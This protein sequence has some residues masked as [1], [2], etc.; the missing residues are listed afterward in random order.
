MVVVG[1]AAAQA[2]MGASQAASVVG[3][4]AGGLEAVA[5]AVDEAE[6]VLPSDDPRSGGAALLTLFASSR[7][8]ANLRPSSCAVLSLRMA[9]AGW[10]QWGQSRRRPTWQPWLERPLKRCLMQLRLCVVMVLGAV[11]SGG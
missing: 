5:V 8:A 1:G 9:A 3:A 6:P 2:M 11:V 10:R 4:G 7:R